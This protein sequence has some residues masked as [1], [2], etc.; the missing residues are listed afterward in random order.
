MMFLIHKGHG[1]RRRVSHHGTG[2]QRPRPEARRRAA[3]ARFDL[4]PWYID[5]CQKISYMFPKA[6][7]AAYVMMAFRIAW[8]KVHHPEAFYAPLDGAGGRMR[9]ASWS[10]KAATQFAVRW[11]RWSAKGKRRRT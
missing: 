9:R 2:A 1:T 10:W 4:P 5:S 6:H 8:F 3:D 11:K 7:A